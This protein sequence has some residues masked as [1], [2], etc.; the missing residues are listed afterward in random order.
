MRF[1]LSNETYPGTTLLNV[2]PLFADVAADDYHLQSTAGRWSR[3]QQAWVT[4]PAN[5]PAIDAGDTLAG[6]SQEPFYN[7]NRLNLGVYGNTAEASKSPNPNGNRIQGSLTYAN[8]AATALGG[9]LIRLMAGNL[10]LAETTSDSNGYFEFNNL[11]DSIAVLQF[12]TTAPWT[13]VNAADAMRILQHFV[14]I[15]PLTGIRL[16]AADT[17]NNQ[18]VNSVDAL[19][20]AKRFVGMINAFPTGD[21]VFESPQISLGGGIL[22]IINAK[23]LCSGDVNTSGP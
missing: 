3:I 22:V 7:G 11:P 20:A 15:N 1:C 19:L 5:S 17:D 16:K 14:N 23:A 4:D 8:P 13:G 21:W 2:D 18:L 9:V 10:M 12:V 6:Y